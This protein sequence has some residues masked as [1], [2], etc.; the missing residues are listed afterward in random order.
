MTKTLGISR[1][2]VMNDLEKFFKLKASKLEDGTPRLMGKYFNGSCALELIGD[3][4][5]L[6]NI[7]LF[8][9]ATQDAERNTENTILAGKLLTNIFP[10]W[11]SG[12][13]FVDSLQKVSSSEKKRNV[14]IKIDDKLV[15]LK[16]HKEIGMFELRFRTNIR[17]GKGKRNAKG[18]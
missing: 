11:K 3:E 14:H 6:S 13:W 18:K 8:I 9:G 10:N 16:R 17:K 5:D 12:Q 4:A 1:A 15:L 2:T 7:T